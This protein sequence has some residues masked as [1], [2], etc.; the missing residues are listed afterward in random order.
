M[1][2]RGQLFTFMSVD[3]AGPRTW[4]ELGRSVFKMFEASAKAWE[5]KKEE[6]RKAAMWARMV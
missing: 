2:R 1:A 5:R 3:Y 4:D 6:A